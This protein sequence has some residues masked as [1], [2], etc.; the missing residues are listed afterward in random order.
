[1]AENTTENTFWVFTENNEWE[2]EI[3]KV[4]FTAT[5]EI[6]AKVHEL[7]EFLDAEGYDATYA[8]EQVEGIPTEFDDGELEECEYADEDEED[9]GDCD[10]CGGSEGYYAPESE[11]EI[12]VTILDEALEHYKTENRNEDS[13]P[14]Y[15]L[16]LFN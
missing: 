15:K 9:C 2:G 1:M 7:K 5:P 14:L 13:D 12:N 4:Y 8:L 11:G 16:G 3:W 10:Y 6:S